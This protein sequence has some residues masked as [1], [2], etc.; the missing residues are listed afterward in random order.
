LKVE[1]RSEGER[2]EKKILI[3]FK[4]RKHILMDF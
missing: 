1:R 2:E 4:I 3:E